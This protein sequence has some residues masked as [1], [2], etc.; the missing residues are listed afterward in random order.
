M[1]KD[2]KADKNINNNNNINPQKTIRAKGKQAQLFV[3]LLYRSI[4]R[5]LGRLPEYETIPGTSK[6]KNTFNMRNEPIGQFL[7]HT[8]ICRR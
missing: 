2:R 1:L 5:I 7:R 3:A 4:H 8:R 6:Y